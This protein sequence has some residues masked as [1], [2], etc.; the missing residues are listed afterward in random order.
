MPRNCDITHQP[1][2]LGRRCPYC[3]WVLELRQVY[4]ERA[5]IWL[6]QCYICG[7]G[8]GPAVR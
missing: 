1:H 3:G 8:V 7:C 4:S 5:R 6:I 2:P